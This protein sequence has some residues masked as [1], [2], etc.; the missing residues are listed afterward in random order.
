MSNIHVHSAN[1]KSPSVTDKVK[2]IV[3]K[4]FWRCKSC[5]ESFQD[6]RRIESPDSPGYRCPR[7][8]ALCIR[9][10]AANLIANRNTSNGNY[11]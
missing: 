1:G 9:D 10:D 7:C 2:R 3:R 5:D 6:F 8:G 4:F 11:P